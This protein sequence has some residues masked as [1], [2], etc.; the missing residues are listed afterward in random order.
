MYVVNKP[1]G[2]ERGNSGRSKRLGGNER[3]RH[4]GKE[5]ECEGEREVKREAGYM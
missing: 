5:E 3:G 2:R 1:S 4:T